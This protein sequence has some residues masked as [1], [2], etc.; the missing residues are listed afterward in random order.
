MNSRSILSPISE[1]FP[2]LTSKTHPN[3][4][5]YPVL[6]QYCCTCSV[7]NI[8]RNHKSHAYGLELMEAFGVDTG[9]EG[10]K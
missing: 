3:I 7:L 5:G 10:Y 6:Y 8:N 2:D 4:F 1:S 9:K